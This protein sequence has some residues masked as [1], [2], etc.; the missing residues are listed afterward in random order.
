MILTLALLIFGS[1]SDIKSGF[2]CASFTLTLYVYFINAAADGCSSCGSKAKFQP[3]KSSTFK[4][5]DNTPWKISY[6]DGSS[7]SG[8]VAYDNVELGG[9]TIKEQAIELA[10]KRSASFNQDPIDGILG[11]GFDTLVTVQGVKTPMD[12]LIEQKLIDKPI[13]G[14]WLGKHNNGG[15]GGK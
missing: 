11:L 10:T 1:V 12:Q 3:S 7:A 14:C 9:L 15:G 5:G 6:G 4:K 8:Y 2:F 13:F